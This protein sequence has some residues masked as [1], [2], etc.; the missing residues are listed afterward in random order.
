MED[1]PIQ[2]L[3]ELKNRL[4]SSRRFEGFMQSSYSS[5]TLLDKFTF[6][7]SERKV[8]IISL[9]DMMVDLVFSEIN[10]ATKSLKTSYHEVDVYIDEWLSENEKFAQTNFRQ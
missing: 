9:S 6:S 5:F 3:E 2:E 7:K 10:V 8:T 4:L 1:H